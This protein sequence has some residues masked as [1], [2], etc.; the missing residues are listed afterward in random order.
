VTAAL[1][2]R[3]PGKGDDKGGDDQS[4]DEKG[5]GGRGKGP[6]QDVS[7]V[8]NSHIIEEHIDVGVPHR[9]AYD[10][11]TQYD[12]WSKI[13]KK[14]SAKLRDGRSNG[15][16]GDGEDGKKDEDQKVTLSSKIG[17]SQREW[18]TEIVERIP[19][20]RIAWRAKGGIQAKGVVTFHRLDDRLTHL[21]VNIEYR[22]SGFMETVG[23]F[24]RMQ[25][26]RARKDLKLFKNYIE[27]RA[28][29]SGKGPGRL[30]GEG[31]R[32]DVDQQVKQAD[33]SGGD[34]RQ[35]DSQSDERDES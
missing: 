2:G 9:V 30:R 33:D 11:W 22:P 31:L 25:R 17:P 20:R 3:L 12:A 15:D 28:E 21:A 27:L 13:F 29:A 18:E 23:N 35:K 14:E 34:D 24:F 7:R 8:K 4:G 6:K 1:S 16:G 32:D 10:Q 5:G 26:R 19:G